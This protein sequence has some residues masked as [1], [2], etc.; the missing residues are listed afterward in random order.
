MSIDILPSENL[1]WTNSDALWMR[2]SGE[3]SNV[4]LYSVPRA[5]ESLRTSSC[6]ALRCASFNASSELHSS[7]SVWTYSSIADNAVHWNQ[8]KNMGIHHKTCQCVILVLL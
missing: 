1:T 7:S 8:M 3:D 2:P 6:M 4:S 5:D